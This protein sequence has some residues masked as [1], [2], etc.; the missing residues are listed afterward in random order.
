MEF[1]IEKLYKQV[2][3]DPR[4]ISWEEKIIYSHV[5]NW[6]LD[7]KV[8]FTSDEVLA[9]RIVKTIP[10]TIAI[11]R[12]MERRKLL[13]LVFQPGVTARIIKTNRKPEQHT[14][15]SLIDIFDIA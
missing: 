5:L 12:N 14:E 6:E 11:L 15:K 13:K 3:R 8:C 2:I 10:E 1:Y 4:F 7:N 9:D